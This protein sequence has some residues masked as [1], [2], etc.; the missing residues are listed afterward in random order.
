MPDRRAAIPDPRATEF[1]SD[2]PL[3]TFL[4]AADALERDER[5]PLVG[6]LL[7]KLCCRLTGEG[8]RHAGHRVPPA[9]STPVRQPGLPHAV[10]QRQGPDRDRDPGSDD[11]ARRFRPADRS[12]LAD[13]DH[14]HAVRRAQRQQ[15]VP[16]EDPVSHYVRAGWRDG[17]SPHPLFDPAWY[18]S[19]RPKTAADTAPLVHYLTQGWRQGLSPHPLFD[20]KWYLDQYEDIAAAGFE[21]LTHYLG[22]GAAEGR[23]PS[24]WFDTAHHVA[25]RGVALDPA[26]NPLVDY[27]QGGAWS[28][29]EA[30]PGF[31][32]A[33]YLAQS[34][35]LVGQ[36]MTPLEHWARKAAQS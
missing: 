25:A 5:L 21:P 8:R 15:L 13:G 30:R 7:G 2:S 1:V 23:D 16:G 18:R 28:V 24:P 34:P 35:E 4:A 36:G 12:T 10:E 22:G 33:A 3:Q 17:L 29:A 9:R 26:V 32:T 27:L 14:V 6:Q 19:Q 11:R 31:P 20:S